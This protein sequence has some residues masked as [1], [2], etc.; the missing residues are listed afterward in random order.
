MY[1][2][3]VVSVRHNLRFSLGL[4]LAGILTMSCHSHSYIFDCNFREDFEDCPHLVVDADAVE[5]NLFDDYARVPMDK[6]RD[7]LSDLPRRY[8]R[9]GKVVIISEGGLR[10]A[11]SDDL[12]RRNKEQTKQ[13]VQSLGIQI[14][15]P[16]RNVV[17]ALPPNK[18]L[19]R[20]GG[21]LFS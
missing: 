1:F 15:C 3:F 2:S 14:K 6:L 12:I 20:S 17:T 11:H 8:W 19:D 7:Y 9:N 4:L 5:I 21:S 16:G 18:L 10:P 13:I